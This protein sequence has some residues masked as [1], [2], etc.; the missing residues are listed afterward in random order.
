MKFVRSVIVAMGNKCDPMNPCGECR[1]CIM[2]MIDLG[3]LPDE[4][5]DLHN[6]VEYECGG[7]ESCTHPFHAHLGRRCK[8]NCDTCEDCGD[9]HDCAPI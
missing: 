3:M 8:G 9:C 1:L 5:E 2:E 7:D 6:E 4:E